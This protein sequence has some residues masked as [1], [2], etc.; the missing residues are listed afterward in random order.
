MQK[1]AELFSKGIEEK[2][3]ENEPEAIKYFEEALKYFPQDDASMYELSAL[4]LND[5][6]KIADAF[7]M[8][9]QAAKLKPDNKW[10]QLRLATVQADPGIAVMIPSASSATHTAG[11]AVQHLGGR[12]LRFRIVTPDAMQRTAFEEDG[13]PDSRSVV[14]AE[15]LYVEKSHGNKNRK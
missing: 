4:Y 5:P 15:M 10:Y 14:R 3:K 13:R 6:Q 9:E 7:N 8:I 11:S 1:N 2:Y 12:G